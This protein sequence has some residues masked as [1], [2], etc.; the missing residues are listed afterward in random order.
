M[1]THRNHMSDE[2]MKRIERLEPEVKRLRERVDWMVATHKMWNDRVIDALDHLS[3]DHPAYQALVKPYDEDPIGQTDGSTGLQKD[4]VKRL[5]D[6]NLRLRKAL[7][8]Y[9]DHSG[10]ARKALVGESK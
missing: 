5:E 7:E 1:K 9:A 3:V 2:P 8:W 6:E 10:V 4:I